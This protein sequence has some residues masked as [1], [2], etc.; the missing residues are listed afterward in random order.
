MA[1]AASF[2]TRVPLHKAYRPVLCSMSQWLHAPT[3]CSQPV[4]LLPLPLS[5]PHLI[6]R[7]L[8]RLVVWVL[9]HL[10]LRLL[11]ALGRMLRIVRPAEGA[12]AAGWK[13]R[14]VGASMNCAVLGVDM[15]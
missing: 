12:G 10:P 5:V 14:E 1:R 8:G 9:W 2:T 4:R 13:E 3:L 6:T 15:H 7:C 11:T